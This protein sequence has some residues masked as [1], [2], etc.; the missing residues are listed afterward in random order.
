MKIDLHIHTQERSPCGRSTEEAMIQRAIARGL[1]AIALTDHDRLVPPGRLAMFNAKY[2]PFR[3][4]GGI[5]VSLGMN[6]ALVLGIQD[7]FLEEANWTYS[8]LV[9]FVA[10]W[11]G[12][13]ALA[14]PFRFYRTMSDE[15][16]ACPPHAM[17]VYSRNTP[18]RAE[19]RIRRLAREWDV[20]LL[21]NSD[22]HQVD[23]LGAYYNE[24]D[25]DPEDDA[26]LVELLRAGT[27]TISAPA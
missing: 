1:D 21:A 25:G 8:K 5:E 26:A 22:A 12:F 19:K 17:E 2:A 23:E 14:H 27:F 11:G 18:R 10:I 7:T 3:V 13:M 24:L 6:H 16:A 15:I 9:D 20:L 4:F